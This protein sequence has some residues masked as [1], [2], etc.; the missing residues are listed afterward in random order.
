[1]KKNASSIASCGQ[2]AFEITDV[3]QWRP[4]QLGDETPNRQGFDGQ[5]HL[6]ILAFVLQ[7]TVVLQLQIQGR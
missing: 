3:A 5:S 7:H 6:T 4:V 2:K 1:M